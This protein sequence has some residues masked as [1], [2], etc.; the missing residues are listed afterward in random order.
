M[1]I[2]IKNG[3]IVDPTQKI[4]K[5]GDILI[6]NGKIAKISAEIKETCSTTIDAKGKLVVPGFIDMH[7]HL[8]EPGREDKET[9]ET[10]LLA[11][12]SGGFTTVCAMPNTEPPCDG[13]ANVKFLLERAKQVQLA[14]LLPIGTITKG[15][16]GEKLTEMGELKQAGCLAVSDDGDSVPDSGLMRRALEYASMMDLLVIDH[17]EDKELAGDGVMH[18]GYWST[19]LGMKP[20][21]AESEATIV[22]RDIRLAELA[23]ARLHIAHVSA[24]ASVDIIRQAKKRGVNVTAEVTPHHFSLTDEDVK[25]FDANMKVNP[26]LR[27]AEDVKALKEGLKDGTIDVIATDHAPHLE[28]EKEKE[29]DYAPFGMIGLETALSLAVTNLV[30]EGY[31]DWPGLIEKLAANPAKILKY[32]RGTLKEG[33]P[34]DITVIAPAVEWDYTKENIR[35]LSKNSPFIGRRMTAAVTEV[36]VGGKLVIKAGKPA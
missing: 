17:C 22:E 9:I 15:R 29:F 24:A 26:P 19:V 5:K 6:K 8:R 30:N 13:Q 1:D 12:V 35:S 16:D 7:T 20:I 18:E 3:R 34:A 21:P 11:A 14:N 23:G 36:L 4:N 25:T 31:L 27:S 33:A 10:G 32:D 28:S 2:L